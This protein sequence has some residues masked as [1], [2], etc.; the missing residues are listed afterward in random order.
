MYAFLDTNEPQEPQLFVN[1]T[2]AH[3]NGKLGFHDD[4]VL[5]TSLPFPRKI[6]TTGL[7]T[8]DKAMLHK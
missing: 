6:S 1:T 2:N 5:A 4:M 3:E 7:P 8:Q